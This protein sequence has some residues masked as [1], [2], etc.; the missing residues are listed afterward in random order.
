MKRA[1]IVIDHDAKSVGGT[2]GYIVSF[3]KFIY[4]KAVF[5]VS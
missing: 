4:A 1:I 2:S 5:L 3:V